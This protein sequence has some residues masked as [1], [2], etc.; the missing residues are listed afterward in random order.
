MTSEVMTALYK[1]KIT[2]YGVEEDSL[3]IFGE[4][5]DETYFGMG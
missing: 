3:P 5:L 4:I 1:V 2:F